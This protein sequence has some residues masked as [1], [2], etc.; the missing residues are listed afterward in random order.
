MRE[1][2]NRRVA[3]ALADSVI[4]GPT[5]AERNDVIGADTTSLQPSQQAE[6]DVLVQ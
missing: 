3:E 5:P 1:E 6:R 2:D 4:R